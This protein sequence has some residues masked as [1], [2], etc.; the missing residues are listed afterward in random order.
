VDSCIPY[1]LCVLGAIKIADDDY[2]DDKQ[3]FISIFSLS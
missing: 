2:D 3:L 1:I